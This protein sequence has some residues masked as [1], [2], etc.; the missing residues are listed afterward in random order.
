MNKPIKEALKEVARLIVLAALSV[1]IDYFA[2]LD[3]QAYLIV[4]IAL[5][6]LDKLIH[7]SEKTELN[8]ILPF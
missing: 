5:R 1:A 6:G 8:G 4:T 7:K 2:G 3:G